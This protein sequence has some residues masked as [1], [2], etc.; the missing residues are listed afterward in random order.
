[1]LKSSGIEEKPVKQLEKTLETAEIVNRLGGG[2]MTQGS[3]STLALAYAG[4]R[5]G[6]NVLD[7][8]KI[9]NAQ[10]R[11]FIRVVH[12]IALAKNAAHL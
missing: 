2:D 6:Y 5:A 3:C 1:M 10:F 8:G 12:F 11:I 4:N 7:R 9:C